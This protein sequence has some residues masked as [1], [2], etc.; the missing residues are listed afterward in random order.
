MR[1]DTMAGKMSCFSV[2][3]RSHRRPKGSNKQHNSEPV[4]QQIKPSLSFKLLII[5]NINTWQ[6]N[7][8]IF[9][10]IWLP[11]CDA[12]LILNHPRSSNS[13]TI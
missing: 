6:L 1:A 13:E 10:K 11:F 5:A 8:S 2:N 4:S 3:H 12:G 7:G 9:Y